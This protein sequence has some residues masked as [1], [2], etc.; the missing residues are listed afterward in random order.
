MGPGS[1]KI[2]LIEKANT[3]CTAKNQ[4]MT[5]VQ[6]TALPMWPGH[7]ANAELIFECNAN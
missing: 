1:M 3:F 6:L 7:P 5:I 2:E 4:K